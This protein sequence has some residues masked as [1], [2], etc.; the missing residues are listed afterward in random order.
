MALTGST[1]SDE[2]EEQ[3]PRVVH[4]LDPRLES[5]AEKLLQPLL[6]KESDSQLFDDIEEEPSKCQFEPV[7]QEVMTINQAKQIL[8]HTM[9][10]KEAKPTP[11]H[12]EYIEK[13]KGKREEVKMPD[14]DI[15]NFRRFQVLCVMCRSV[16]TG[17]S[18]QHPDRG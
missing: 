6:N 1:E 17:L 7:E 13:E 11:N 15:N 3:D 16:G 12:R 2:K 18:F 8:K 4:N 14:F 9:H 5:M 10:K